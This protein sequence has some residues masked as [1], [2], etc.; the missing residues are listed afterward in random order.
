MIYANNSSIK[1]YPEGK[2]LSTLLYGSLDFNNDKNQNILKQTIKYLIA[3]ERFSSPLFELFN[4]V[5]IEKAAEAA[6]FLFIYK[7][8]NI[9][10]LL[11][12]E[13]DF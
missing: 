3:F 5:L 11:K 10:D 2:L 6:L 9:Q 12:A 8:I 7:Y 4:F 13:I 1:N